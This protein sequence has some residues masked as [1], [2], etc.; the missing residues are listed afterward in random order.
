MIDR[1]KDMDDALRIN[2][3]NEKRGVPGRWG[4]YDIHLDD[5]GN[6]DVEFQYNPARD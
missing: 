4:V 1:P 5:E 6:L 2:K 3:E